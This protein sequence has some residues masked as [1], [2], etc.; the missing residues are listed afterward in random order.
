MGATMINLT[1]PG[2]PTGKGRPRFAIRG[3]FARAYTP[4]KTASYES[5]VKLAAA[6]A[7]QSSAPFT[8]PVRV[9][10]HATFAPP[11]SWSEKKR[12]TAIAETNG[13][14]PAKKPDADNIAKI[15]CDAMNGI[16]YRDDAQVV[17][18]CVEKRYG[19]SDGVL[20]QIE[21]EP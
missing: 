19:V 1:I 9:T 7:M 12:N 8:H 2:A 13:I 17:T 15:I 10:I 6:D 3:G 5:L 11:A 21:E 18:L 14:R 4:E 20:V 16:V